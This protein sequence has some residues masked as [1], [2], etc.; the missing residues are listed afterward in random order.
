M[1]EIKPPC[2]DKD[3]SNC[4]SNDWYWPDDSYVGKKKWICGKCH[5]KPGGKLT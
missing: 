3:C 1:G 4:R 5:P 2:P